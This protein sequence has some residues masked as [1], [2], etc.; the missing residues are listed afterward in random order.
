MLKEIKETEELSNIIN[1]NWPSIY[2]TE[3]R[4]LKMKN[5]VNEIKSSTA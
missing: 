2:K 3:I 1:K 4:F 5:M